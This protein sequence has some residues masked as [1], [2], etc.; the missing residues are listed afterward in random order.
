M[1][2]DCREKNGEKSRKEIEEGA[3][4]FNN[5]VEVNGVSPLCLRV[6][7]SGPPSPTWENKNTFEV[8]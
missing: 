8:F 5:K 3:G 4:E 1:M 2:E 7:S 6:L